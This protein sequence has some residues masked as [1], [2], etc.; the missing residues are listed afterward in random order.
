MSLV[1]TI[2]K[3][4]EYVAEKL[5]AACPLATAK[6]QLIYRVDDGAVMDSPSLMWCAVALCR[7]TRRHRPNNAGIIKQH[8]I[9]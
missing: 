3:H 2:K 4:T 7:R 8:T 5:K 9:Y 6:H 1:Y